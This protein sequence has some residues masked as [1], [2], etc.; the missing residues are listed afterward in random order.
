MDIRFM[1]MKIV[2]PQ[3]LSAPAQGLFKHLLSENGLA[4]QHDQ[5]QTLCEAILGRGNKS[6]HK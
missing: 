2:L 1:F 4:N 3:G 5:S 6:L